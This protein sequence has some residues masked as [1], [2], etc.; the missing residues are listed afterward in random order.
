MITQEE[1]EEAQELV[2]DYEDQLKEQGKAL[3]TSNETALNI[4]LVIERFSDENLQKLQKHFVDLY[5][6]DEIAQ[7]KANSF[8]VGFGKACELI[9]K[10]LNA[11]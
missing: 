11:L 3:D 9:I 1:Y 4:D 2:W 8:A 5:G 6:S 7:E 10:D